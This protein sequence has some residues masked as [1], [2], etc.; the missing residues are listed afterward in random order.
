MYVQETATE[1]LDRLVAEI[2]NPKQGD[3]V[4]SKPCL[5]QTCAWYVGE[6]CA[7]YDEDMGWMYMPYDRLT[8]YAES[9]EQA[10]M[11]LDAMQDFYE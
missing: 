9:K 3:L 10:Q 7:E 1:Q 11:W 6:L 2:E 5:M 4:V 8:Q